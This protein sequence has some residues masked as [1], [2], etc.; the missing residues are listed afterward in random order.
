VKTGRLALPLLLLAASARTGDDRPDRRADPELQ[1][2]VNTAIASGIDYLKS[3][4]QPD[5][6]WAYAPAPNTEDMTAGMTALALYAL[7]ASKVPPNDPAIRKGVRWTEQKKTCYAAAGSFSTYSASLLVLA[8]TRIDPVLHHARIH[9]LA[10]SIGNG[11]LG[12]DMWTYQV[13]AAG[14]GTKGKG[15][16][17]GERPRRMQSGD[18]SNS[19]FAVLS[20]WAASALAGYEVPAHTWER[21]QAFY[22]RT[23]LPNGAWAYVPGPSSGTGSMTSA[24]LCSYVYATAGLLGGVAALPVARKS[25]VA[26][27]G[28]DALLA[29]PQPR[30]Y[31]NYY[32]VYALERA[33]TVMAI[34]EEQWYVQGARALVQQQDPGGRWGPPGS[35]KAAGGAYETSLALLFLSRA[36]QAAITRGGDP[37]G[38]RKVTSFPTRVGPAQLEEALLYYATAPPAERSKLA[39]RFAEAGPQA[40]RFLVGKLRANDRD[41]RVAAYELLDVLVE[42]RFLFDPD[43]KPEDRDLMLIPIEAFWQER[44]SRVVWDEA[45][46]RFVTG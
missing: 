40:V 22:A 17:E 10:E 18:N 33:G 23:Q 43:A 20:L 21:I 36:T 45:K 31:R 35:A 1:P 16:E 19:Q 4:Q 5:G 24:G 14:T 2:R 25:S 37:H 9:R 27:R 11:Q 3:I 39:P 12:N 34:P 44:G 42:K 30:D 7:S 26:Q 38:G 15:R 46:G 6:S 28:V 8:L 32:F 13:G 41:A 29:D